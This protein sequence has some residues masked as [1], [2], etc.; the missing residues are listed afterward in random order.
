MK[1]TP[2]EQKT[3]L[4]LQDVDTS[5]TRIAHQAKSL[6]QHAQLTALGGALDEIR[7]R[8]AAVAGERDDITT[9]LGRIES[10]VAVVEAR[11]TR[12]NDRL[13]VTASVKDIAALEAELASLKTRRSTLED[14]EL[15]VM[16]RLEE[17][18]AQLAAIDA[19]REG[20]AA[21]V[22]A[23]E[24]ERD[25]AL[26]GL[27]EAR[28]GLESNRSAIAGGVSSELLALYEKRRNAGGGVGAALLR[29][30][31]CG[32]CTMSIT[33]SDL[34]AVRNTSEDQ[35]V[36]CPDCGRILVRTEE[37]GISPHL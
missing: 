32:G 28:T 18:N 30:R 26:D 9:E 23:A 7:R 16:E 3:L 19:E 10:D 5:L 34:E 6:A 8:Y 2:T 1:A 14:I 4:S 29:A 31:S 20:V 17:K 11:I 22:S 15:A 13:Q 35:V 33:G 27:T 36:F 24:F 21:Q 37:S 25:Q 12:D